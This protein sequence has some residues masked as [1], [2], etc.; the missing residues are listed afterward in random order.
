MSFRRILP[1]INVT[2]R[3]LTT[4]CTQRNFGGRPSFALKSDTSKDVHGSFFGQSSFA[5]YSIVHE[6]SVVNVKGLVT[7]KKELALFAPLG[8]GIQT[9]SGSVLNAAKAQ[10]KDSIV[11]I[12]QGGVGLSAIMGAAIAGCKTIIGVDRVES[13]LA[14][15]KEVGATHVINGDQ[16]PEGKS[17]VE[18]I[19]DLT[20]GLGPTITIDTSGV[21]ALIKAG[22]EWTRHHGRIY[23]V[24]SAPP[25]FK[26]E[27]P[28]FNF[29]VAGKS[30]NGAIEGEA[31]PAEFVPK[32]IE[33]YR[34]GRFPIDKFIKFLPADKFDEGLHGMKTGETIKPVLLWS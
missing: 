4:R 21:P 8:C 31:D 27:V 14:L 16:L 33:W 24:G 9:G 18:A 17:I 19:K 2:A 22:V 7:D 12:G 26:L 32:M 6:R 3:S 30:F 11:I 29:M 1:Y 13:R 15:A 28:V 34:E 10:P 25:D 23:Q 5:N 20:D